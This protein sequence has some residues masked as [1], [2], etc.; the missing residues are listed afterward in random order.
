M[1]VEQAKAKEGQSRIKPIEPKETKTFTT[2]SVSLLKRSASRTWGDMI[3]LKSNLSG[4]WFRLTLK[5]P[6]GER[7]VREIASP[8]SVSAK[9]PWEVPPELTT[10]DTGAESPKPETEDE[11]N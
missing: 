2:A 9:F 4:V 10:E 7:L 8:E 3:D 6:D 1:A 5:G 11:I